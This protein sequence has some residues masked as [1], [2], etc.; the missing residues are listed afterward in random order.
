VLLEDPPDH[1]VASAIVPPQPPDGVEADRTA[2]LVISLA[3][4][5]ERIAGSL[6][7]DGR[8]PVRPSRLRVPPRL[9]QKYPL[10]PPCD[11]GAHGQSAFFL[12]VWALSGRSMK[13]DVIFDGYTR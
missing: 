12:G 7:P 8:G 5:H 10:R 2:G 9:L 3:H 6:E 11:V 13:T 4:G 1:R